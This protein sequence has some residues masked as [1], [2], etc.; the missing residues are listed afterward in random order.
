MEKEFVEVLEMLSNIS[1]N[2]KEPHLVISTALKIKFS[3]KKYKKLENDYKLLYTQTKNLK[4]S[5]KINLRASLFLK[6]KKKNENPEI[7]SRNSPKK[8]SSF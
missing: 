5:K 2:L 7:L 3:R 6:K 4:K 8:K 1:E